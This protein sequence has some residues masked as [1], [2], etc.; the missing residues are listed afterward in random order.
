MVT[1]ILHPPNVSSR[2]KKPTA[3]PPPPEEG[4]PQTPHRT[5]Q[6]CTQRPMLQWHRHRLREASAEARQTDL[7][8]ENSIHGRGVAR[9]LE[10][11]TSLPG[12]AEHT[13]EQSAP[14]A[15]TATEHTELRIQTPD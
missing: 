5:G 1:R 3:P 6:M 10:N 13:T 15:A 14:L 9:P 7:P 4:Q 11:C 12:I 2:P 8:N